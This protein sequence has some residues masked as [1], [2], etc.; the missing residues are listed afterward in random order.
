MRSTP[1]TPADVAVIEAVAAREGVDEATLPPLAN[2]V[3]P[4][5]LNA[6]LD[7]IDDAGRSHAHV[8]FE[9]CDHTVQ[10]TGDQQITID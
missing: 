6:V 9:Y 4:E 10:V 2:V 1:K 7:S 5:A 8:Q 3:D